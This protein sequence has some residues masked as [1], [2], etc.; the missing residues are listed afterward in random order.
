VILEVKY[1][2]IRKREVMQDNGE[3][4]INLTDAAAHLN[5]SKSFL[6]QKGQSLGIPRV[7][8]GS[9]Y[10]YKK[11]DLDAWLLKNQGE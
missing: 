4:W 3:R 5:V 8:L 10:R 9:K 2:L 6:Y 11:S 7:K 1:K